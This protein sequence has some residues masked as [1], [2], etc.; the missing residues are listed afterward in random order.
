MND[1]VTIQV[2]PAAEH[3]AVLR[4]AIGGIAGRR[5]FTLDQ[6][7][8]LRMAVEEAANQL[9]RHGKDSPITMDV[10]ISEDSIEAA[11]SAEVRRSDPI[12][13]ESSFSW[14]I[15]RALAD[16][17]KVDAEGGRARVVLLKRRLEART[18][19]AAASGGTQDG[20]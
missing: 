17:L 7:D 20:T 12:I 16:D 14:M 19:D 2:P 1:K 6:V 5:R 15:L 3:L 10:T 4:T 11:L 13:D 9:L 8:D 18:G